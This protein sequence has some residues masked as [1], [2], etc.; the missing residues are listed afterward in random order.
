MTHGKKRLKSY[1][2]GKPLLPLYESTG[3]DY[4]RSIAKWNPGDKLTARP[5]DNMSC[6]IDPNDPDC[7]RTSVAIETFE[8]PVCKTCGITDDEKNH[9]YEL[10]PYVQKNIVMRVCSLGYKPA[11]FKDVQIKRKIS[12]VKDVE[13]KKKE[14]S[15]IAALF[16]RQLR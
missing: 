8:R 2:N 9:W 13:R 14:L 3:S 5:C 4:G 16:N 15:T 11:Q 12:T 6:W 7:A 1:I 10:E